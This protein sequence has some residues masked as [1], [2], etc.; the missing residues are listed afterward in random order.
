MKKSFLFSVI[1]ICCYVS[2]LSQPCPDSLF[3][4]SQA[5]I[6][7]FQINYPNCTEIEGDVTIIGDDITNL[8]G[9]IGLSLIGGSL[10]VGEIENGIGNPNLVTLQGLDSLTTV[11]EDI[12]IHSN[13]VLTSLMGLESLIS[14]EG[15]LWIGYHIWGQGGGNPSLSSLAALNHLVSIGG[16]LWIYDNPVLTSLSGLDNVT[17]IG[18]YLLIEENNALTSLEGLNNITS[19][20]GGL[21]IH[22]NNS[23]TSLTG[24]ENLISIGGSLEVRDNEALISLTGL[25]NLTSI[26][27]DFSI[28]NNDVLTSLT[29]LD[30]VTSIG[31]A[32]DIRSNS[33][34]TNLTGLFNVTSIGGGI[35]IHINE[36]LTSLSGLD[37]IDAGSIVQMTFYSNDYLSSCEVQSICDY[38][39]NPSGYVGIFNNAVGCN[40]SEE[41]LDSCEANAVSIDEQNIQDKLSLYPNPANQELNISIDNH[42]I[43]EVSIR[44]LTGQQVLQ[45]RPVNGTIDIS[46][47]QAGM[48]I[49]EVAIEN[50]R[51]R[52]KLLV[53]R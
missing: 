20:G 15:S 45:E 6:D 5:Q 52:Q 30:N 39:K 31:S 16:S 13:N 32:I 53:Q 14:I 36:V 44:T 40:S 35:D 51:L 1:L 41:V 23:L 2:S 10:M 46:H 9:L 50:A 26:G 42:T 3:I 22:G 24:L 43:D 18:D 33:A 48:Y 12:V 17:L 28:I 38:L 49:V 7:S 37:N 34:L 27:W 47:L 8:N 19:I 11:G 25:E 29:G 21:E 4:T